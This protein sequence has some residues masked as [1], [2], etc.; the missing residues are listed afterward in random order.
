MDWTLL[1]NIH[2]IFKLSF[3]VVQKAIIEVILKSIK[4]GV[5][6]EK[7]GI[8]KLTDNFDFVCILILQW[9]FLEMIYVTFK[10]LQLKDINL[11]QGARI[12]RNCLNE[13]VNYRN[14]FDKLTEKAKDIGKSWNIILEFN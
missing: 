7:V 11:K 10:A 4:S 13:L 8:I 5:C 14:Q 12:L 2:A 9:T 6:N 1:Y 3:P